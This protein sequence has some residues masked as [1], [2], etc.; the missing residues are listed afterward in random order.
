VLNEFNPTTDF[1]TDLIINIGSNLTANF[2]PDCRSSD[3]RHQ[4]V[5]KR[6]RAEGGQRLGAA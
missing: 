1:S 3:V 4:S 6:A 2:S 5:P